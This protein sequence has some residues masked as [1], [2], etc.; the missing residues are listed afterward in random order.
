MKGTTGILALIAILSASAPTAVE[1]AT[2]EV[3]STAHCNGNLIRAVTGVGCFST[4]G[5]YSFAING[6]GG[7][8]ADEHCEPNCGG[9]G[10]RLPHDRYRFRVI[11]SS[12]SLY[13]DTLGPVAPGQGGLQC[14]VPD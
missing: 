13:R 2:L 6:D 5:G 10:H 7:L 11:P 3:W 9:P 4:E 1:A 8:V 14:A 12:I